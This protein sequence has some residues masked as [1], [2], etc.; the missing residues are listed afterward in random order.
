MDTTELN[1]NMH[2]LNIVKQSLS[3]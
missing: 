2:E 1:H 3:V